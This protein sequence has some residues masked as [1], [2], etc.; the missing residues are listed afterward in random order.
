[1]PLTKTS[2]KTGRDARFFE[3]IQGLEWRLDD[4][5]G[6]RPP[7]AAEAHGGGGGGWP[8]WATHLI[9]FLV[10][11]A[12]CGVLLV[13]PAVWPVLAFAA[14]VGLIATAIRRRWD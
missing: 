9:A 7:E 10:G 8:R 4:S 5:G 11:G 13:A 14:I 3:I 1:M 6:G 12:T 2:T